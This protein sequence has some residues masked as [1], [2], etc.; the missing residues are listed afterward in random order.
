MRQIKI[1]KKNSKLAKKGRAC[2]PVS[3][4]SPKI[5][6]LNGNRGSVRWF[7]SRDDAEAYAA[8]VN[9]AQAAGGVIIVATAG[10]VAAAVELFKG[11]D[12]PKNLHQRSIEARVERKE[13][14]WAYGENQRKNADD[15]SSRLGNV[16]C[17]DVTRDHLQA[18]LD[19]WAVAH[20]TKKEKLLTIKLVLE[21][22]R[23]ENWIEGSNPAGDIKLIKPKYAVDESDAFKG[24]K[25]AKFNKGKIR[26]VIQHAESTFNNWCDG[27]AVSFAFQTGLRFGEQSALRWKAV[28][29]EKRRVSVYTSRRK[30]GRG[31]FDTGLTKTSKGRRQVPLTPQLIAQLK[32]WRVASQ[33]SAADDLVFPTRHG[34]HQASA[35]NWRRRVLHAS[36]RAV[37]V[38]LL[39][40][41]DAR[42]FYASILLA[43]YGKDWGR[44]AD[45]LGHDSTD[46]SRKQYGHWIDDDEGEDN[47]GEGA[48]LGAAVW[49]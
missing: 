42:H 3:T 22:A 19:A 30:S 25:I 14:S 1:G 37:G 21:L 31:T 43:T 8:E 27:L 11:G 33:Y 49:G 10:T 12:D 4:L 13:I 44:I 9:A 40:W 29:F 38:D 7:H 47:S 16:L 26:E 15:W 2:F 41:H 18:Q 5:K 45:L 17:N 20:K 48:A 32:A 6:K 24:D 39:R 46:F 23:Q 36:C 34:N 35:D 28:D